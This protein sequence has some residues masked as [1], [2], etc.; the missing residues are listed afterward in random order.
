V[1]KGIFD[2]TSPTNRFRTFT[3][4]SRI[5]NETLSSR[6]SPKLASTCRHQDQ[7][8]NSNL[9]AALLSLLS[10]SLRFKTSSQ[11][12]HC[13]KVTTSSVCSRP[14]YLSPPLSASLLD[15]QLVFSLSVSTNRNFS[16]TLRNCNWNNVRRSYQ[17]RSTGR[18]E[19]RR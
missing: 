7:I 11:I 13:S 6:P 18:A 19:S 15:R 1:R 16:A 9:L 17:L 2:F 3:T 12:P 14:V 10:P 8:L 5:S 4:E